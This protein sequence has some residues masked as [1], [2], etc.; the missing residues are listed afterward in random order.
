MINVAMGGTLVKDLRFQS[1]V[2]GN[3]HGI[4]VAGHRDSIVASCFP[5]SASN[6]V[7]S[8]HHQAISILGRDLRVTATALDGVVEA[9]EGKDTPGYVVG[10]QFHPE[11]GIYGDMYASRYW[12]NSDLTSNDSDFEWNDSMQCFVSTKQ[13][14]KS[15]IVPRN[16]LADD[17]YGEGVAPDDIVDGASEWQDRVNKLA[18]VD[19]AEAAVRGAA[20]NK[21][22]SGGY[23]SGWS[24]WADDPR[25]LALFET[26]SEAVRGGERP[27]HLTFHSDS[28]R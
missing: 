28:E 14:S 7:N 17:Y 12:R 18:A 26:F 1:M 19:A 21:G 16:M 22:T 3:H 25:Y 11:M 23:S 27:W 13:R 5:E 8:Y 2:H 4:K 20:S 24:A 9:I 10:V 15:V 6:V